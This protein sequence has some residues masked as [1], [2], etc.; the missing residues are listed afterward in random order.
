MKR[1]VIIILVL[2]G[3]FFVFAYFAE[4]KIGSNLDGLN[5]D[6]RQEKVDTAERIAFVSSLRITT[7]IYSDSNQNTFVGL[8]DHLKESGSPYSNGKAFPIE[9]AESANTY[10]VSSGNHCIDST[11]GGVFSESSVDKLTGLCS[12]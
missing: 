4:N 12:R 7:A 9:C 10:S 2:V 5:N 1:I 3:A 8:C 6:I 11:S